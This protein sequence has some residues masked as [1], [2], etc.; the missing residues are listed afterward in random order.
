V[1]TRVIGSTGAAAAAAPAAV[2]ETAHLE[3]RD[4]VVRYGSVEAL[5]GVSFS[6]APGERLCLLGPSGCGKTT[7]LQTIAGFV[8]ATSGD[9]LLEGRSTERLAPEKRNIGIVF[10]NYALFPH[11]SVFDNVA[12]G[13]RMRKVAR[14]EIKQRVNEALDLVHLGH[15]AA[16][17]SSELSGGEQQRIAFARAAVI[18][19]DLLLLD[20]PFS[21]LDARLRQ[22]LRGELLSLLDEVRIATVMVTHD[23][24]EAMY[25]AER[26][27]VMNRGTI[28]QL[29][30]PNEIYKRPQTLFVGRFV[31]ESNVFSGRIESVD[32]DSGRADVADVGS[33]TGVAPDG[34]QVGKAASV[35]VRPEALRVADSSRPADPGVNRFS[36]RVEQVIYLGH[37]AEYHLRV[38]AQKVVVWELAGGSRL[39]HAPGDDLPVEVAWSETYLFGAHA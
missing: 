9:V 26:I 33:F 3:V 21:N 38:G 7:T 25:I 34:L 8:R 22:E 2:G 24:E 11:L 16:K 15:A 28:E 6:V 27:A 5:R 18:Q 32:G 12:F 31:G 37:R 17:R 29:G 23:Q 30:T 4:L 36:G 20:E 35:L 13:L 39:V 19:P 10:Q 1:E 14:A